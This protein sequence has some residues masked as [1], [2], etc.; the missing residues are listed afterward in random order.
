MIR[1]SSL[2]EDAMSKLSS[3]QVVVGENAKLQVGRV[4]SSNYAESEG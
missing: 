1:K 2:I 3:A 4:T